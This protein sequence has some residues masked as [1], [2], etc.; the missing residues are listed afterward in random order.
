MDIEI[1]NDHQVISCEMNTFQKGLKLSKKVAM[2]VDGGL[3]TF[4]KWKDTLSEDILNEEI[5]KGDERYW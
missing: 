4:K 2:L 5:F 3:Y 1:T